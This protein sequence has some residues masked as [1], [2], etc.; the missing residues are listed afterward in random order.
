MAFVSV[1]YAVNDSFGSLELRGQCCCRSRVVW[2][3]FELVL[4]WTGCIQKPVYA[5]RVGVHPRRLSSCRS[6]ALRESPCEA[7]AFCF[8]LGGGANTAVSFRFA[9]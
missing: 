5:L 2:Q 1:L 6:R 4:S 7:T 9:N 8:Q 3:A